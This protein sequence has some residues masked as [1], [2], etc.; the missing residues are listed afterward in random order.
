MAITKCFRSTSSLHSFSF[1][2]MFEVLLNLSFL[3][4][5]R[6]RRTLSVVFLELQFSWELI[7]LQLLAEV[8]M[9]VFYIC[10]NYFKACGASTI[11][12]VSNS[13]HLLIY[14]HTIYYLQ[15]KYT[16]VPPHK[17]EQLTHP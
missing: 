7:S 15:T 16:K 11:S 9:H 13:H 2:P 14:L 1:Y 3:L 5:N 4:V 8:V 10:M 6:A 12:Q 17:Y